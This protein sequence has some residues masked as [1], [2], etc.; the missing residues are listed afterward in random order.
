VLAFYVWARIKG[1]N[2][3]FMEVYKMENFGPME[4]HGAMKNPTSG[5]WSTKK[6][7]HSLILGVERKDHLA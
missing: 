7:M 4:K 2:L 5:I 3:A 6:I 1:P